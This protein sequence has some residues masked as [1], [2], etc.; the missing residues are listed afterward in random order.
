MLMNLMICF[1]FF[2]NFMIIS[3]MLKFRIISSLLLNLV[4]MCILVFGHRSNIIGLTG[5]IGCGK[6]TV[7]EILKK[8]KAVIIDADKISKSVCICFTCI[9]NHRLPKAQPSSIRSKK[10]SVNKSLVKITTP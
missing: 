7:C 2:F 6:S 10:Y 4:D 3:F 1:L 9:Y 5:G 8:Y